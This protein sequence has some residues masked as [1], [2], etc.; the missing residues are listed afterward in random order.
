M[1]CPAPSAAACDVF[2]LTLPADGA[3]IAEARPVLRWNARPSPHPVRVQIHSFFPESGT[4]QTVDIAT[5]GNFFLPPK[6]LAEDRASVKVRISRGCPDQGAESLFA[7]SANFHID[8]S[9]SCPR[10]ENIAIL[11][12]SENL[13]I[14]WGSVAAAMGYEVQNLTPEP[15]PVQEVAAPRM[16]MVKPSRGI[17]F[18]ARSLCLQAKSQWTSFGVP[19]D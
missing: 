15:L 6:P 4:L 7:Q 1:L 18:R 2:R 17:L 16:E 12:G 8:T 3:V 14:T 5:T 9:L 13:I 19:A 11:T 10:P